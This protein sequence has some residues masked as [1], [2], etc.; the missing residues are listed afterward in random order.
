MARRL[1]Y[2]AL[3]LSVAA[4]GGGS[5]G[6]PAESATAGTVVLSVEAPTTT[7]SVGTPV[8]LRAKARTENT[9]VTHFE[10]TFSDGQTARGQ[11]V[12]VAFRTSGTIVARVIATAT[13]GSNTQA[14]VAVTIFSSSD[15]TPALLNLP[16]VYGDVNRNGRLEISDALLLAQGLNRVL[17]LTPAQRR[18]ADLDVDAK[19]NNDDLLLLMQALVRNRPL[20]SAALKQ[21]IYPGTVLP[22]VSPALLGPDDRISVRVGG[23]LA[24][25]PTRIAMGYA[26]LVVPAELSRFGSNVPLEISV[27]DQVADTIALTVKPPVADPADARADV[28]AFYAQWR[29]ALQAHARDAEGL[30]RAAALTPVELTTFRSGNQAAQ[31]LLDRAQS[32]LIAMLDGPEGAEFGRLL[33][34]SLYANGM[35]EMRASLQA[36][37]TGIDLKTGQL[38]QA[39]G[40]LSPN[41][42]CDTLIPGLCGAKTASRYA[43]IAS[44]VHTAACTATAVAVAGGTVGTIVSGGTAAVIGIKVAAVGTTFFKNVCIPLAAAMKVADVFTTVVTSIDIKLNSSISA[45]SLAV[46]QPAIVSASVELLNL[47]PFCVA[48]SNAVAEQALTDGLKSYLVA[49]A[50]RDSTSVSGLLIQALALVAEDAVEDLLS[51]AVLGLLNTSGLLQVVEKVIVA[52]CPAD[53]LRGGSLTVPVS[54]VFGALPAT[55]GTLSF[56]ADGTGT[57]F[58]PTAGATSVTLTGRLPLCEVVPA[59]TGVATSCAGASREVTITMGDNGN[60]L[61]DIF[62]VVVDGVTVLTSSTP[63]TGVAVT[64]RLPVGRTTVLMRGLAAPDGIGTYFI[65]FFG[66]AVVSGD[67]LSGN[68]LTPGTIKQFVIEVQP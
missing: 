10:W 26:T 20:P 35:S 39:K 21:S 16:D 30:A 46:G 29:L 37:A 24:L 19:T 17:E 62:E 31:T 65:S 67:L 13:D 18:A 47:A 6:V 53:P 38:L 34:Q 14:E 63:V 58:C 42:V 23:A 45:P 27:N 68:D 3:V 12:S 9:S 52:A 15:P 32:Q 25:P 44:N 61:D 55:Q 7:A 8:R 5:D 49:Q 36:S 33:Q 4:C 40:L 41:D 48:T 1:T 28:L 60:A 11:D 57:Y 22:I 56:N 2:A 54:R 50:M 66:A 64:L 43:E 59:V 51:D